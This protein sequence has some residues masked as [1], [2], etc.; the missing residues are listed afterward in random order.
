MTVDIKKFY[1]NCTL[2]SVYQFFAKMLKTSSDVA[3]VLTNIVTYDS[4][5]PTGCPT[6]QI[7]AFYAYYDMFEEIHAVAQ[8]FGCTFTLYVD[9]MTFSSPSPISP[10]KLTR[11]IEELYECIF[12]ISFS[13]KSFKKDVLNL[14]FMYG[15]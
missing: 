15:K 2:D 10:Q 5:I 11:A 6:S 12:S 1:D 13:F 14:S 9:D 3:E 4:S 7:I 8:H